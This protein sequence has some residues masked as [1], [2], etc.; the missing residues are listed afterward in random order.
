MAFF[1]RM[2]T[3]TKDRTRR[4]VVIMGRRTWDSIPERF[5][6]LKGRENVVLTSSKSRIPANAAMSC[7]NL[8]DALEDIAE[9]QHRIERVWVI[10][11]SKVY[12]VFF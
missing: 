5:K 10:G 7:T 9:M 11:G 1:T 4:N 3:D 2:T 8:S 6:P 12:K